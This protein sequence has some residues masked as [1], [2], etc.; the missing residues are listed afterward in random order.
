MNHSMPGN[1]CS[2]CVMDR[3]TNRITSLPNFA[4]LLSNIVQIRPSN[5][6]WNYPLTTLVPK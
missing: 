2:M 3:M 1:Y 6:V 5:L 4:L